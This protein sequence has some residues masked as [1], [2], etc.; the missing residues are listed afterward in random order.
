M[1]SQERR[2]LEKDSLS[3]QKSERKQLEITWEKAKRI[4]LK[5]NIS[6]RR[7]ELRLDEIKRQRRQQWR[8]W[9]PRPRLYFSLQSDFRNLGDI[10]SEDLSQILSVPIAIPNPVSQKAK[11]Y[12]Y[13][14]REVQ[15]EDSHELGRRRLV[16]NLYRA[17]KDWETLT[18]QQGMDLRGGA[19]EDEVNRMLQIREQEYMSHENKQ[20]YWKNIGRLLNRPGYNVTPLV[21]T[22]PNIDYSDSFEDFEP[23]RNYAKLAY[24][25]SSYE[26]VGALLRR[27]GMNIQ[28][29]PPPNATAAVP[30]VYDSNRTET[31]LKDTDDIQ[32]FGSWTKPF[33]MTGRVAASLQSAEQQVKF[34][35]ES[36]K[37]ELDEDDREWKRLKERYRRVTQQLELLESRLDRTLKLNEGDVLQDWSKVQSTLNEMK[38]AMRVKRELDME[39]WLWDDSAWE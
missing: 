12:S 5:D 10:G 29:W 20:R 36:L 11:A 3:T 9:L 33:D 26:I 27:K 30:S 21:G 31:W 2:Q 18:N 24:R 17:F 22:A 19:I 4:A 35:R 39:L 23:G 34:I 8:E 28:R 32:L 16:I 15:A 25:L 7:S 1:L 14:L 6:F 13:A 37:Q 38:N